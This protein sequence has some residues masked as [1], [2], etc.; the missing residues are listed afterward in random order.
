MYNVTVIL[1]FYLLFE[2]F[3]R[4][5]MK[6]YNF[7]GEAYT[8]RELIDKF[9][10]SL[11]IGVFHSRMRRGKTIEMSLGLVT[12]YDY[13]GL[14]KLEYNGK[15]YRTPAEACR[16]FGVEVGTFILRRNK[17][18]PFSDCI[19]ND[20][21]ILETSETTQKCSRSKEIIY[22]GEK[23][24]SLSDL[25]VALG[26]C[27]SYVSKFIE[28]G[29]DINSIERKGSLSKS[30]KCFFHNGVKYINE[31]EFFSA[32]NKNNIGF[33]LYSVRRKLLGMSPEDSLAVYNDDYNSS[34]QYKEVSYK[35][36]EHFCNKN[37]IRVS[38]FLHEVKKK[39]CVDAC[40]KSAKSKSELDEVFILFGEETTLREECEKRGLDSRLIMSRVRRGVSRQDAVLLPKDNRRV[41]IVFNGVH[42]EKLKDFLK[43]FGIDSTS[44]YYYTRKGHS[45]DELVELY[46]NKRGNEEEH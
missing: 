20:R 39:R 46:K 33:E 40:L 12:K 34:F 7:R 23:F 36:L 19:R 22:R 45:L 9:N 21:V 1:K 18:L 31:D 15:K 28:R 5:Q 32:N 24:S 14:C 13:D 2:R 27:K 35:N 8:S 6:V 38:R 16:D 4:V 17:G 37:K 11:P 29:G 3:I 43:E 44:Y 10:P 26:Y 42:Y 41:N 25:S 30:G